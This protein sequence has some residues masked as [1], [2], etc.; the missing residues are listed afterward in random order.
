MKTL[1][2]NEGSAQQL[3]KALLTQSFSVV[4]SQRTVIMRVLCSLSGLKGQSTNFT[5]EV[6]LREEQLS[7]SHYSCIMLSMA[8]ERLKISAWTKFSN[9]KPALQFRI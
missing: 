3:M 2:V 8:L 7:L 9:R 6:Q 4:F 5:H 1:Q